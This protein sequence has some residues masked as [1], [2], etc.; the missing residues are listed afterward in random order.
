MAGY[1]ASAD[2]RA[3]KIH[4]CVLCGTKFHY[5]ME[6]SV[7]GQGATQDGARE[8]LAT[9]A[10]ATMES[11]V[12]THPC[13]TCGM[14]QPEMVGATRSFQHGFQ[15]WLALIVAG[16]LSIVAGTHGAHFASVIQ[17]GVVLYGALALWGY[18]TAS[19]NPNERLA[20][21][22]AKAL[23]E[24]ADGTLTIL[25]EGDKDRPKVPHPDRVTEGVHMPAMVM[26][27][28]AMALTMGAEGLRMASG[29]PLNDAWY[30]AVVGPGDT[31]SYYFDQQIRSLKG[32]WRGKSF[33]VLLGLPDEV[34][35]EL[36]PESVDEGAVRCETHTKDNDWGSSIR[37]K[38]SEKRT[39]STIYTD[40]T[41]PDAESLGGLEVQMKTAIL[42]QYPAMDGSSSF[43]VEQ[44]VIAEEP[45]LKLAGPGAGAAYARNCWL[46]I[47]GSGLLLMF[48][49][50]WLWK[51]ASG[52]EGNPHQ[53]VPVGAGGPP[54]E[55]G[56][57]AAAGEGAPAE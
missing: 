4:E 5:L 25:E 57:E 23:A 46:G 3:I 30:P 22:H 44:N 51:R 21:G 26:L 33:A 8:N 13:P 7:Q 9:N 34:L 35:G 6:R 38:S 31:S 40:V 20:D 49:F 39:S 15:F 56:E 36:E 27:V 10:Q 37:V 11:N 19:T 18:V 12:D 55:E 43:K 47:G 50:A 17:A 16:V 29:T 54:P 32:Y 24:V 41:I 14:V 42:Y 28:T 2:I 1:T 52:L 53:A 45:K 48:A